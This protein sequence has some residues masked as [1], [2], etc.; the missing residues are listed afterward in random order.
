MYFPQI[1]FAVL[2]L[3]CIL[4]LCEVTCEAPIEPVEEQMLGARSN[5]RCPV[6]MDSERLRQALSNWTPSEDETFIPELSDYTILDVA[7]QVVGWIQYYYTIQ[8]DTGLCYS[9][10]V[11]DQS[12]GYVENVECPDVSTGCPDID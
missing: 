10:L 3:I 1:T 7:S 9:V 12:V 8:L 4:C 2:G 11:N 6:K 5:P